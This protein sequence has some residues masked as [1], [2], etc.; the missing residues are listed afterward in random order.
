MA[1]RRDFLSNFPAL[2]A[3]AAAL[4]NFWEATA[5]AQSSGPERT[6]EEELLTFRAEDRGTSWG[7]YYRP[8][9][10]N[11]KTAVVIMHPRSNNLR[12]FLHRP[13]TA[14]GYGVLGC[15]SRWL[16]NDIN[17]VQEATLLDIAAGV[18]FLKQ[19]HQVER[20]VSFGH[21][22]GGG[23]YA[24]YQGQV[25]TKPPGRFSSTPA[26]DPPD[27]NQFD[28]P[29]LD[30]MIVSCAHKGEGRI[31]MD[32]LDAAV[33]DESDPLTSDWTL[34]MYDPRNGYR[35]PPASSKYSPEFLARYRIAQKERA[36]RLDAKAY[37]TIARQRQA[38]QRMKSPEFGR[39]DPAE[40]MAV[41]RAAY[42]DEYMIIYRTGADPR[43]TD[44]SIDP[45]DRNV[46][47]FAWTDPEL[48]NYAAGGTSRVMTPRG[49]LSTWSGPSSRMVTDENL[50]KIT[51]PTLVMGATADNSVTGL[52]AIRSSY[53]AS[54]A[55]DKKLEWVKGGDHGYNPVEP[56]AG[57]KDTQAEAARIIVEWLRPRFP[58]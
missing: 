43:M 36:R 42:N 22:G 23:L 52:N 32:W 39:L 46:G 49:Y 5:F 47:F 4:L 15:A 20:I 30:G 16:N 34:D 41:R 44:R 21:S 33:V 2:A 19:N 3:G 10:K 28:L 54:A 18:K 35:K 58:V 9:G 48:G 40:Q 26:G 57:G 11:P 31:Q 50:A 56:A 51:I 37:A 8:V 55:K 24:F 14:A 25:T 12:H 1:S 45:S 29:P 6:V 17:A 7:M 53:E 38:Q 13:L 27:L